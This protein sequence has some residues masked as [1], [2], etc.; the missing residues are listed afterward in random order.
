LLEPCDL[1]NEAYLRLAKQGPPS[2]ASREQF[3][4]FWLCN[5]GRVL[6]D[7]IRSQQ[8]KKRGAGQQLVSID[9]LQVRAPEV[10]DMTAIET[11]IAYLKKANPE[12]R[13]LVALRIFGDLTA[14]EIARSCGI[15]E[16]TARRK[17]AQAKA[18]LRKDLHAAGFH[19]GDLGRPSSENV[20]R[21]HRR[22]EA[23]GGVSA[24]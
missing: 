13:R 18:G 16:S 10:P 3:F 23:D 1:V 20:R 21:K 6:I 9:D 14:K 2:Y 8:A 24:G 4:S 22:R 12:N 7:H 17:W 11:A 5:M 15:A 19:A